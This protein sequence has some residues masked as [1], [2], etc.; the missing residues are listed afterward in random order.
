MP[1]AENHAKTG[2]IDWRK[3]KRDRR[4]VWRGFW[5]KAGRTVG[6]VP[7]LDEAVAAYFCAIDRDTPAHVK[8]LLL[9]AIA[10]FVVPTDMVPDFLA[11][12][13]YTDDASV[14]LGAIAAVRRHITPAHRDRARAELDRLKAGAPAPPE[15]PAAEP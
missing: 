3:I 10:Y 14:L 5:A 6:R 1:S 13:G 7:F 2:R 12:L 9:G 4:I 8:A 15:P 11:G